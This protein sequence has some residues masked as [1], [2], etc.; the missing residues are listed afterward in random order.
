MVA[1]HDVVQRR[2]TAIVAQLQHVLQFMDAETAQ[3][4]CGKAWLAEGQR[5]PHLCSLPA[6]AFHVRAVCCVATPT[7]ARAVIVHTWDRLVRMTSLAALFPL[8]TPLHSGT[9]ATLFP[10][11]M[12]TLFLPVTLLHCCN[13]APSC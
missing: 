7:T 5:W 6:A 12:L 1:L 4:T 10:L 13:A 9:L 3:R 8:A 11:A 2:A